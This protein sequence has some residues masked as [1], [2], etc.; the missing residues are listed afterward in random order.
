MLYSGISGKGLD[1]D[2]G[3]PLGARDAT[4]FFMAKL[5]KRYNGQMM[6]KMMAIMTAI[7]EWWNWLD[8]IG[9][10]SKNSFGGCWVVDVVVPSRRSLWSSSLPAGESR[11]SNSQS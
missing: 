9:V 8:E 2:V 1:D 4:H 6:L 5:T 7:I 3:V 11:G 10:S